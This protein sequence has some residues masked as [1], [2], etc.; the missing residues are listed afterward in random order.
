[1]V[2]HKKVKGIKLIQRSR[3]IQ[4]WCYMFRKKND[5]HAHEGL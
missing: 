1:M 5:I 3:K 4:Y 2:K